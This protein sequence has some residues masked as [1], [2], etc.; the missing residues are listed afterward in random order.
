LFEVDTPHEKN[1]PTLA[2]TSPSLDT[3]GERFSDMS[4]VRQKG[5]QPSALYDAAARSIPAADV[6]RNFHYDCQVHVMI[7]SDFFFLFTSLCS[8]AASLLLPAGAAPN[9]ICFS[10]VMCAGFAG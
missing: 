6:V 9:R 1:W 3:V 2:F 10:P 7:C 5:S 4:V 8:N